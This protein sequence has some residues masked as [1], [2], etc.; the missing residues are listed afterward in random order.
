VCSTAKPTP[1]LMN[2]LGKRAITQADL[3]F[4]FSQWGPPS[5]RSP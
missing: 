3:N 1:C 5:S 2:P 4:V